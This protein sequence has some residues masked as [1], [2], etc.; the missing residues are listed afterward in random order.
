[1]ERDVIG[2]GVLICT[3]FFCPFAPRGKPCVGVVF[4][5]FHWPKEY[6]AVSIV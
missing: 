1:V 5:C 2:G 6:S 3:S 4:L